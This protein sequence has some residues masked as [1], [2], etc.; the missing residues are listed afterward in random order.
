MNDFSGSKLSYGVFGGKRE[1]VYQ[2]SNLKPSGWRFSLVEPASAWVDFFGYFLPDFS[3]AGNLCSILLQRGCDILFVDRLCDIHQ[4]FAAVGI[5]RFEHSGD[6]PRLF[7]LFRFCWQMTKCYQ[8][9]SLR[10]LQSLSDFDQ[11]LR[12][13]RRVTELR[14]RSLNGVA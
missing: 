7:I 2:D 12:G 6:V 4:Q 8:Y 9:R 14:T 11:L 10:Y 3:V 1:W 5:G 13:D